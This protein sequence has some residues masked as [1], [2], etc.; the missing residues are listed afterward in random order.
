MSIISGLSRFVCVL[1][2]QFLVFSASF[3]QG[4]ASASIHE[5]IRDV[6]ASL[7]E[8]IEAWNNGDIEAFMA[9]YARG[10]SLRFASGNSIQHG[11]QQ[12]LERYY[13]TYPD[14]THMGKLNFD[15]IEKRKLS[16]DWIFI[17]GRFHLERDDSVGNLEGLFTLLI[18]RTKN[19]WRIVADHTSV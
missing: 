16:A 9:F 5:D 10:D 13:R 1:L 7:N 3:G 17:F 6:V 15:L 11:W 4:G 18:E 2:V 12:T 8:Q 14:K 19:G